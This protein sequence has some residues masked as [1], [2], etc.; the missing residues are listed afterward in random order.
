V[1]VGEGEKRRLRKGTHRHRDRLS[2]YLATL[3]TASQDV[4]ITELMYGT[5]ISHSQTRD[6]LSSM[7]A[8]GLMQKCGIKYCATEKGREL[9]KLLEQLFEIMPEA[10]DFTM[11][12]IR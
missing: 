4:T 5:Y 10:K 3:K 8:R 1:E 7:M 6:I 11:R 9:A 12:E 2:L